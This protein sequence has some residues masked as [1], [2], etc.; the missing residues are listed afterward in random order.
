MHLLLFLKRGAVFL[1][2]ELID[3]VVCAELPD[4]EWDL[5]GELTAVVTSQMSHGPCGLEDN[6]KAP[7]IAITVGSFHITRTSSKSSARI[8]TSRF[9]LPSKPLSIFTSTFIKEQTVQRLRSPGR[10][11][12]LPVTFK[13]GTSVLQRRSGVYSSIQR[14]RSSPPSSTWLSTSL[15]SIPFAL[16]TTFHPSRLPIGP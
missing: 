6:P 14:T 12:K 8:S 5:T 2:P 4:R 7:C 9:A 3:E 15:D 16:R 10:T 1:T 13:L 11:T